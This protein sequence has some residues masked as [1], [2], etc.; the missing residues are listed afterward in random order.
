MYIHK[1]KVQPSG[2]RPAARLPASIKRPE[3][4]STAHLTWR[5]CRERASE[6]DCSGGSSARAP[7]RYVAEVIDSPLVIIMNSKLTVTSSNKA[8][9]GR[10]SYP[11]HLLKISLRNRQRKNRPDCQ[12][13]AAKP[14]T[15]RVVGVYN[16]VLQQAAAADEE[17]KKNKIKTAARCCWGSERERA[18]AAC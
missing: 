12:G 4:S 7:K 1:R 16:S 9:T 13:L 6:T 10:F 14:T 17:E 5:R 18:T 8:H 3:G 2:R 11:H 15:H